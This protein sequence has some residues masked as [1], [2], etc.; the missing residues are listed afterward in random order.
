MIFLAP[1]CSQQA[2][3]GTTTDLPQR[4][5]AYPQMMH[6]IW[7]A[8][9]GIVPWQQHQALTFTVR[10]GDGPAETHKVNLKDRKVVI[11]SDSFSLGRDDTGIWVAPS[12]EAFDGNPRFYHNLLFYFYGIPF[13]MSDPGINIEDTGTRMLEGNEY[14]S[15]KVSFDDGVGDAPDD[16]YILLADPES[17]KL[18]WLL[19]TVT[20]FVNEKVTNYNALRYSDWVKAGGLEMPGKLSGYQ[21]TGDTLGAKRYEHVF[22]EVSFSDQPYDGETFEKPADGVYVPD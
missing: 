9:G 5:D 15:V 14:R 2:G 3:E 17:G 13:L 1:G 12:R 7:D 10:A 16:E 20:F 6:E 21:F 11:E 22:T 4:D 18:E 19:Y 8:H